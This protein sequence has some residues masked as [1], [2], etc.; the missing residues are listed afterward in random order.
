MTEQP[1]QPR[2]W[3]LYLDRTFIMIWF[4]VLLVGLFLIPPVL[5][6]VW[7]FLHFAFPS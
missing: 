3:M 2:E 4:G 6:W 1:D 5:S 7:S